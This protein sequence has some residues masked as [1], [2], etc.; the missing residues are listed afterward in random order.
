MLDK[1][2]LKI[3]SS[4]MVAGLVPFLFF[5]LLLLLEFEIG[6]SSDR[7][8]D[9]FKLYC[10]YISIFMAGVVWGISVAKRKD[11]KKDLKRNWFFFLSILMSLLTLVAFVAF[12]EKLFFVFISSIFCFYLLL[13]FYLYREERIDISYLKLRLFITILVVLSLIAA[14]FS[15]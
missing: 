10:F 5:N 4:F 11:T 6:I 7:V 14:Q 3:P 13:D 12:T 15:I 1:S 2:L 9:L 8:V